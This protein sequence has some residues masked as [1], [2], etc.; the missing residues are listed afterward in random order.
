MRDFFLL[1]VTPRGKYRFAPA[2]VQHNSQRIVLKVL[3]R[4]L[5]FVEQRQRQPVAL[6]RSELLQ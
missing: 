4:Q 5:T 2:L 1:S 6:R 3:I